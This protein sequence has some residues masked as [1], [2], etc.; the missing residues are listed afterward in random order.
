M[1][2]LPESGFLRLPQIIGDRKSGI[3][4]IVPVS[5]TTWWKG[6]RE[7]RFPQGV[8]VSPN[9]TAWRVADIRELIAAGPK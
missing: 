2:T 5:A 4:P 7:G 1:A 9:V 8:K 6:V 3:P